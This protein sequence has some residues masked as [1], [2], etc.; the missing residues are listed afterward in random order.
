[1]VPAMH[2]HQWGHWR[3]PIPW[4]MGDQAYSVNKMSS[5]APVGRSK[6]FKYTI[7]EILYV[8]TSA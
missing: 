2:L 1:M 6:T 5:T 8:G 3:V 7:Y 4:L